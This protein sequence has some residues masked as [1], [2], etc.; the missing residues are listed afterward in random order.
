MIGW[1]FSERDADSRTD[2]DPSQHTVQSHG[3]LTQLQIFTREILQNA[4]DNALPGKDKNHKQPVSVQF[5]IDYLSGSQKT[6]FLE[7]IGISQFEKHLKAIQKSSAMKYQAEFSFDVTQLINPKK[8]L[9]VLYIDDLG[10][11]GLIGPDNELEQ[12]EVKPP[13]CFIGLCRNIGDNQKEGAVHGGTYG[14]GKTVLWKNSRLRLVLFYTRMSEEYIQPKTQTKFT[15]RFFGQMR[16]TGHQLENKL[17]RGEGYFGERQERVTRA[18][19]G[20]SADNIAQKT[21]M[22]V[23]PASITGTTIAV[24][25][26]DDP[27]LEDEK[28]T[29]E[30][31]MK[32][33]I[34]AA[35][36]YYWPAIF[37]GRL[38]VKALLENG[39]ELIAD[40]QAREEFKAFIR[41]YQALQKGNDNSVINKEVILNVPKG[42]EDE[43]KEDSKL[44][45]GILSSD[46]FANNSLKNRVALIRGAGLVVGYRQAKRYSIG[47]KDCF[48]V[49]VAGAAYPGEI[50]TSQL[51][52]EQLLGMSEPVSHDNWTQNSDRL[53]KWYGAKAAIRRVLDQIDE[54]IRKVTA[55]QKIPEGR[56]APLLSR[57]FNFGTDAGPTIERQ[58]SITFPKP[59]EPEKPG[60]RIRIFVVKI[61]VPGKNGLR[62]DGI[63]E[64]KIPG[65]WKLECSYEFQGEGRNPHRVESAKLKFNRIKIKDEKWE[66]LPSDFSTKTIYANVLE[67]SGYTIEL[68]GITEELDT[69]LAGI[70]RQQLN[71]IVK[72]MIG[73]EEDRQ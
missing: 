58:F 18:V 68:S 12:G 11:Y 69:T 24:V 31:T 38:K 14:F 42:P 45:V 61:A 34:A 27:D 48:A 49:V 7:T 43:P 37:T 32:G 36:K 71:A 54:A 40:P 5:R 73:I 44:M 30:Q 3:E 55:D 47:S 29:P 57:M 60:S 33:I 8:I 52:G 41:I 15:S 20:D 26:F 72:T 70:A 67:E 62:E 56:A 1:H 64:N 23:R 13:Y 19:Y 59:P 51:R 10:T 22:M 50:S 39:S 6:A 63:P 17:F 9:K 28:E 35:E 66:D 2:K 4:L 25:D 53:Q 21:N 46:E 16:L 65:K